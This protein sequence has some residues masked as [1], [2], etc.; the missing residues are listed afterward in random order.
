MSDIVGKI[1]KPTAEI[2]EHIGQKIPRALGKGH[3]RV[4]D[5][6]HRAADGFEKA[7]TDLAEK[8]PVYMIDHEGNVKK[9]MPNGKFDDVPLDDTS[10]IRKLLGD[11]GKA[12]TKK[13]GEYN[14]PR[15][16]DPNSRPVV[17]PTKIPEG[18][19]ELAQA[20][21]RARLAR[22]DDG[23]GNY[24]A[25]R[26]QGEDGHFILVGRS[27]PR[28]TLHSEQSIGVPFLVH[29]DR[30]AGTVTEAYTERGPCEI[31]APKC[32]AWLKHYFPG[33]RVEHSFDYGPTKADEERGNQEHAGYINR[34]FGRS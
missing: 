21:Q 4:G 30:L 8:V 6:A 26:Y 31:R 25:F 9:L 29:K 24:A 5:M 22:D 23:A 28:T 3:E 15:V 7:E 10:G 1:V 19:S 11:D 17:K 27:K 12:P 33:A 18:G 16:K 20:T 2:L 34:L 14:L 32:A 13:V